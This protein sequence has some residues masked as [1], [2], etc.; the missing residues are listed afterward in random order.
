MFQLH[1]T[2]VEKRL[3]HFLTTCCCEHGRRSRGTSPP[4]NANCP[5][6]ILWYRYKKSVLWPSKYA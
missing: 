1:V 3:L 6:Q 2:G 4:Q 5:H